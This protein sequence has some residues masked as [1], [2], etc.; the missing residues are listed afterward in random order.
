MDTII[1]VVF[2]IFGLSLLILVHELGHF[3]AARLCGVQVETFS[4]GFGKKLI[5][6]TRKGINYQ[7]SWFLLGG[8]CKLKGEMFKPDFTE[9]DYQKAKEEKNSFLSASTI[10]KVIIVAAGPLANM[11]FAA[12]IFSIIIFAGYTIET[13]GTKIILQSEY[14]MENAEMVSVARDAGLQTG[15][16]ILAIDGKE[17]NHF[18]D[19]YNVVSRSQGKELLFTIKRDD[20]IFDVAISPE[21]VPGQYISRIGIYPWTDPVVESVIKDSAADKAGLQPGDILLSVNEK[22]IKHTTAFYYA[23]NDKPEKV[24]ISYERNG[25]KKNTIMSLSYENGTTMD[26]GIRFL[27]LR[28]PSPKYDPFTALIKGGERTLEVLGLI[29][30]SFAILFRVGVKNVSDVVAGPI[31]ITQMVGQQALSG[32]SIGFGAGMSNFFQFICLISV[33]LGF[34]NLLPIPVLDG[35]QIILVLIMR[36]KKT[37]SPKFVMRYQLVGFSII[38]MLTILAVF[39]DIFYFLK[40]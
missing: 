10:K 39:S 40:F 35:G 4:L 3:F 32:F 31:R 6:F 17:M 15:D 38:A 16:E 36:I 23:L 1:I 11:F 5:G 19:I 14:A 18:D 37:M 30:Q 28:V 13:S 8:Y 24:E 20:T 34:M 2:G 33:L 27:L 9:E 22:Q 21:E 26:P 12:L 25:E 7:I 29:V